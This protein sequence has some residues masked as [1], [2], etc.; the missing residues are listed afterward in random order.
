[1]PEKGNFFSING[2]PCGGN[3]SLDF[4]KKSHATSQVGDQVFNTCIFGEGV[5]VVGYD[6]PKYQRDENK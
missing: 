6:F 4:S 5:T 1:M 3:R 2:A